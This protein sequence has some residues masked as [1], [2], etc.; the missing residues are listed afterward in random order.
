M[1]EGQ[2][3]KITRSLQHLC[4]LETHLAVA[5]RGPAVRSKECLFL[6]KFYQQKTESNLF[7]ISHLCKC[8]LVSR[9]KVTCTLVICQHSQG[10]RPGLLKAVYYAYCHLGLFGQNHVS[11][12]GVLSLQNPEH[13]KSFTQFCNFPGLASRPL[14]PGELKFTQI[15]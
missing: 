15:Q 12:V 4:K 1:F 9:D 7:P 11:D 3:H 13:D 10:E 6:L 8:S 5:E 14:E 2:D